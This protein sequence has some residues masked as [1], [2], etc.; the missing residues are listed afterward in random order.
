MK[1]IIFI[2]AFLIGV[3]ALSLISKFIRERHIRHCQNCKYASFLRSMSH[4]RPVYCAMKCKP[5]QEDDQR[6]K[7]LFCI[8]F[9]SEDGDKN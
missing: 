6:Q 8:Y 9:D 1:F 7:A 5:I 3:I 2:I 4:P